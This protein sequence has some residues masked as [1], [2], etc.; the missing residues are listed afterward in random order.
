MSTAV[1]RR[2]ARPPSRARR[3]AIGSAALPSMARWCTCSAQAMASAICSSSTTTT[4]STSCL[5]IFQVML[6][7]SMLP[8]TPSASVG[9]MGTGLVEPDSK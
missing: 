8:D 4:S 2:P 7:R 3:A 9:A 6:S 5:H 1:T